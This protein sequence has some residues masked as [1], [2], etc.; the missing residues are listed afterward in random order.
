MTK[1]VNRVSLFA[2]QTGFSVYGRLFLF[3][4]DK[5]GNFCGRN[6]VHPTMKP[7]PALFQAAEI[8][9]LPTT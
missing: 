6:F 8:P 3:Y 5:K 2:G 9:V 7:G 4:A 1:P